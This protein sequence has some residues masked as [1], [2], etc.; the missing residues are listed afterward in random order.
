MPHSKDFARRKDP[1]STDPV[2]LGEVVDALLAEEAFVRGMPVAKLAQAWKDIVGERLAVATRPSALEN[3]I[4]TIQADDGPWGAQ[5]KYLA[6]QIRERADA[7][8]GGDTVRVVRVTAIPE[9]RR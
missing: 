8:L 7:A 2:S 3:G 5:A 9:N 1:R 6:E 4:L